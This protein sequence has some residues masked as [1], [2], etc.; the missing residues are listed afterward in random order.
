MSRRRRGRRILF[1]TLLGGAFFLLWRLSRTSAPR[2]E[3]PAAPAPPPPE[4]VAARVVGPLA[5]PRRAPVGARPVVVFAVALA[6]LVMG[7]AAALGVHQG[8]GPSASRTVADLPEPVAGSLG[9]GE[10][11][12]LGSAVVWAPVRHTTQVTSGPSR[13]ARIVARLP[14][15]TPEGT[16]NLVLVTDAVAAEDGGGLWVRVNMAGRSGT[17]SGW[18]QR[19][20]LGGY[21]AVEARLTVDL[22]RRTLTL[23]RRG[24]EVFRAPVGVGKPGAPTPT[25]EFFIR[26]KL[27]RY[28]SAFY[29]PLAFGTSARSSLTDWP[30]GGF[31]GIHGT[32]RPGR[33]PGA[34]S[35]GCIRLRNED[36]LRLARLLP[37]GTPVT[38][39]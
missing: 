27:S 4:P 29:G 7:V 26:N 32:N 23:A 33:I 5:S 19:D 24:R 36:L 14:A 31:V 9:V 12:A 6:M 35:H 21:T 38:I 11:M 18:V 13:S 2:M 16:P 3:E 8:V 25:G 10:P 28:R 1:W 20:T 37:V 39:R 15:R 17:T 34:V 30:A 22:S